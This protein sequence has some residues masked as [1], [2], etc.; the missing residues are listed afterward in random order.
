MECATRTLQLPQLNQQI[1]TQ[2]ETPHEN[3]KK[4]KTSYC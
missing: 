4:D 1:L 3:T 2:G